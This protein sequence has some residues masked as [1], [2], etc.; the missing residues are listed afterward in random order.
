MIEETFAYNGDKTSFLPFL[1]IIY[2]VNSTIYNHI[3]CHVMIKSNIWVHKIFIEYL[4]MN[5]P[6]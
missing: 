4:F 5:D 6:L 2:N 1:L 3:K